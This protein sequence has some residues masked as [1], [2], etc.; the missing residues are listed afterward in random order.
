ML[1]NGLTHRRAN[2]WCYSSAS[3]LGVFILF[4]CLFAGALSSLAH[5]AN[6]SGL[7]PAKRLQ[8]SG[9]SEQAYL[10]RLYYRSRH[11]Q[12]P[13]HISLALRRCLS[14]RIPRPCV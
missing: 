5:A 6:Q 13:R 4:L 12:M 3:L 7:L 2:R 11:D 1:R 8:I 14:I 9:D 10:L